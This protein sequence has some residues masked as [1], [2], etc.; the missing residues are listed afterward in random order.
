MLNK[1][2]Y[3]RNKRY[4]IIIILIL[5]ISSFLIRLN[6]ISTFSFWLDEAW[7]FEVSQVPREYYK[8]N[9]LLEFY[10]FFSYENLIGQMAHFFGFS[11]IA[12]RAPSVIAGSL[13]VICTY[14]LA[15][16]FFQKN[17]SCL[18]ALLTAISPLHIIYSQ[19]AAAYTIGSCSLALY[20]VLLFKPVNFKNILL[21]I[22][23]GYI[24]ILSYF[25]IL[26]FIGLIT[27]FR[28]LYIKNSRKKII[29][30]LIAIL[31]LSIPQ[32]YYLAQYTNPV[33]RHLTFSEILN[34][35]YITSYPFRIFSSYFTFYY[36][37]DNCLWCTK[38]IY[39]PTIEIFIK[40]NNIEYYYTAI[41]FI[42]ILVPFSSYFICKKSN[43]FFIIFISFLIF[44][45]F[46][47][48]QSIITLHAEVRYIVPFIP[49][50]N[51]ILCTIIV[52]P[53]NKLFNYVGFSCIFILSISFVSVVYMDNSQSI[54]KP[55]VR[56]LII[57]LKEECKLNEN[58]TLLITEFYEI[59]IYKFYLHG[60]N[61]NIFIQPSFS[62]YF[63]NRKNILYRSDVE[64]NNEDFL[65]VNKLLEKNSNVVHIISQRGKAR[66][67]KIAGNLLK[68]YY[69]SDINNFNSVEIISLKKIER[70]D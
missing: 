38:D 24:S 59:P 46:L 6:N 7:R 8:S 65:I 1:I 11:T 28:V 37:F 47:L 20:I 2:N 10:H 19:E 57:K 66:S 4:F 64:L 25:N 9:I 69:V 50:I 60:S 41:F 68:N 45:V 62:D 14:I 27:F 13:A 22:F 35:T 36:P 32:L 21:L 34:N 30:C 53:K 18:C 33:S 39:Y 15:R 31:I 17:I 29:L 44:I 54:W 43:E 42:M 23:F 51:L 61:C 52:Y 16:N 55:D 70:K 67:K 56:Q 40:Y 5:L 26:I 12:I 48:A 63:Y 49:I 58:N 3:P